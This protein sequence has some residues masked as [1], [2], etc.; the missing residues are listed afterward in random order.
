MNQWAANGGNPFA[1]AKWDEAWKTTSV[2]ELHWQ[3][4]KRG[5][6]SE[7]ERWLTALK[8]PR[9]VAPIA[10]AGMIGSIAHF[11]YHLGAIR[12]ISKEARGPREGT[13]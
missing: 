11:A 1:N 6:R 12:Q 9:E 10:L 7:S 3:E 8:T 2:N 13:Y 4:I 5:L